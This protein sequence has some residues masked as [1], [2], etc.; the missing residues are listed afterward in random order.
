MERMMRSYLHRSLWTLFPAIAILASSLI[1]ALPA[2]AQI[3]CDPYYPTPEPAYPNYTPC[4]GTNNNYSS[5]Y[6]YGYSSS[7]MYPYSSYS[8]YYPYSSYSSYYPYSSYSGYNSS[9]SYP[10]SSYSS[11]Y[12]YSSYKL[13][14]LL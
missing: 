7:Y 10:Y 11:Y 12:P 8:S 14:S 2:Q 4:Y 13:L 3:N 5:S 9:Y 1:M 6:P